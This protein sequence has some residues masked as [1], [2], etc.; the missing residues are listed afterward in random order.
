MRRT[1]QVAVDPLERVEGI[2]DN[3]VVWDA[4]NQTN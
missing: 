1:G 2:N 4:A 3:G